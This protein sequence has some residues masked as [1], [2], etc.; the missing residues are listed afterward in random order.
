MYFLSV[1]F[2]LILISFLPSFGLIDFFFFGCIGYLLWYVGF[3][4]RWLLLLQGIGSRR[5]ASVV[6]VCGLSS[7]GS[8]ALEH[9]LSSC[10][11][12]A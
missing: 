10:G 12:K 9:R 3:L 1:P 5:W 4:L 7:C 2:F 11:A 6:V 8:R